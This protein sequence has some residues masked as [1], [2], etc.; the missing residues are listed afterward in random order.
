M[1]TFLQLALATALAVPTGA[2]AVVSADS[3]RGERLFETQYCIQCH[4]LKGE[5]GG[6][7]P[8]LAR[9]IGQ[10]YTPALLVTVM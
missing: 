6:A 9:R 7:A 1:G 2:A 10:G 8:D 3:Q 5:G 4:S